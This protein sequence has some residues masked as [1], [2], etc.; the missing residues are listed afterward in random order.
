MDRRVE[1]QQLTPARHLRAETLVLLRWVAIAGQTLAMLYVYFYLKFP[2]PIGLCFV[3][4]ATSSALN[5]ALRAGSRSSLRL[6]DTE[7]AVLL[8]YDVIQL[9][10][11]LYLTGGVTNA[12]AMF[13]L[14]P[15]MISAVSLP[16]PFTFLL[17]ILMVAAATLLT[18]EFEPLPWREGDILYFPL[19]YRLGVWAA[20]VLSAGFIGLYAGRVSDEARKLANALSATELVL[21]RAQHLT[22]LDGLAAAAAHELGTPLATIT[23]IASELQKLTPSI[24]PQMSEDLKLLAQEARRCREILRKLQSL[25]TD[26]AHVLNKLR[27]GTLIEEAVEPLRDPEVAIIVDKAGETSEPFCLRNP[28]MLYGLGNLVENAVDFARSTVRIEARWTDRLVSV[29]IEDDGPGFAPKILDRV[30]DP[31]VSGSEADRR[32][33]SAPESGLGL[34]LFIA[35]TLLERS[36]ALIEAINIAPPHTGARITISWQREDFERGVER[37]AAA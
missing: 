27:L 10:A 26:E 34:G 35:T 6:D 15:V 2:F 3:A 33:K 9:A 23:L 31:Y 28:G 32:V 22:Q 1:D 14:A 25:N 19:L 12:F 36:G 8:A 11:L 13:L 37:A 16:R 7:A 18:V 24:A 5:I 30:G 17:G 20:L 29:V 4:I 21:E